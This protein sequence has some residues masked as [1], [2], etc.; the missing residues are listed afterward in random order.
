MQKVDQLM[1]IVMSTAGDLKVDRLTVLGGGTDGASGTDLAAKL[2]GLSEQLKAATGLD[3]VSAVRE[4]LAGAS[5]RP[6]PPA[7]APPA[8][9]AARVAPAVSPAPSRPGK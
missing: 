2:I 8:P 7:P 4:R 1:R 3:V 9:A 6:A 5:S